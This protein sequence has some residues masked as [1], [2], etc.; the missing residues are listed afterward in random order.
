ME[1]RHKV[2]LVDGMQGNQAMP[3][4]EET[5]ELA[6]IGAELVVLGCESED[7]IISEAQDADAIL[8]VGAPMTRRVLERLPKCQL[9]VRYGIGYDTVDVEAATDNNILLVNIPDFCLEEVSNHAIA[10]LL[11]CAKKI[12]HLNNLVKEGRWMEAKQAQS[13]MESI[14]GQTLGIIGCGNIGRTTARKAK[15]FGLDVLGYDPYVDRVLAEEF[16]I[17]LVKLP[18]LLD[19]SDYISVHTALTDETYHLIGDEQFKLMKPT[20]FFINTARGPVVDEPALIRAFAE[21]RIAGA[22][23]D[24][25][26]QEPV[27]PDNP[28]LKMDNVVVMPHSASYSDAAFKRLRK[29]VGQEAAR[30]LGGKWPKNVVNKACKPKK[31]LER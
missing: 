13:P 28:L 21:G 20:A 2:I 11:A 7:D 18:E 9:I 22:G 4:L 1:K 5:G 26:E 27:D 16:D 3:A 12:P 25:F 29:S 24:V 17:T 23:L 8:T 10:L 14:H 30:L 31:N 6:K 15:C 19:K